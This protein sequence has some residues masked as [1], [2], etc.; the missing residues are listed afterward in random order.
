MNN[1]IKLA[2]AAALTVAGSLST[3]QTSEAM[4]LSPLL[5]P[6]APLVQDI[7]WRCGP[8]WRANPWG[9]CVPNRRAGGYGRPGWHH[10]WRR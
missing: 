9:R 10:G 3:V 1:S 8:G 7:G 2:V 6:S 4:P 5:S